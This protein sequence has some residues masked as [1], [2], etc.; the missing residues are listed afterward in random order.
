MKNSRIIAIVSLLIAIVIA[1]S[2]CSFA[3]QKL[4]K[5]EDI[6]GMDGR[7]LYK[8]IYASDMATVAVEETKNLK[9]QISESFDIQ[10]Y[11]DEDVLTKEEDGS[12]EILLGIT[13][14]DES[15][16]AL[17][18]LK[19]NRANHDNDFLIKKI[20]T[21][22]CV[23]AMNDD[24]LAKAI[25]YLNVKYF[26]SLA[27]MSLIVDDF[28]YISEQEYAAS[29]VNIADKS[30]SEYV[31]VTPKAMSLLYSEKVNEFADVIL[32]DYGFVVKIVSDSEKEEGNEIIIGKTNRNP[33]N[34]LNGNEFRISQTGNKLFIEGGNDIAIAAAMD[35]LLELEANSAKAQESFLIE[36][37]YSFEG[38]AQRTD[39]NYH[40]AW[41]DEFNGPLDR[42]IWHKT[43]FGGSSSSSL[44]GG[45]MYTTDN[46]YTKNGDAVFPFKRLNDKDFESTGMFT[47]NTVACRYGIIEV[48]AKF[49]VEPVTCAIWLM[50]P[51]FEI[52]DSNL[53][54]VYINEGKPGFEVDIVENFGYE[55]SFAANVHN[56][57]TGGH[58]SLDTGKFASK[59]KFKCAD[60]EKLS[61]D[62]HIYS[63][64]W[65]P[66]ALKFAIDGNVFFTYDIT[67]ENG[68]DFTR[69]PQCFVLGGGFP[70]AGYGIQDISK[71]DVTHSELLVD[72]W[73]VYQSDQYDNILWVSPQVEGSENCYKDGK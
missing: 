58:T 8:V 24:V 69:S 10:V 25:R 46:Y 18:L 1:F 7:F 23:V 59:K 68:G 63:L 16:N 6:I 47:A 66:Y 45:K 67:K 55:T 11:Y 41:N 13:N 19:N 70:R 40:L 62:Y 65:T 20:G 43:Y 30:I 35:K 2:G 26:T 72:Y 9:A 39:S 34:A 31:I 22:I 44:F 53:R 32:K 27:D 12:Y 50:S 42:T 73:R 38:T 51:Y 54:R 3:Q 52:T 15:A 5:E 14:R 4:L 64:Q 56:W 21:K 28:Q 71:Y 60:G 37:G 36:K 17:E 48:R 33:E 57:W 29:E 49:P 61:D